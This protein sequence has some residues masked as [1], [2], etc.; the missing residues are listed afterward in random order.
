MD[1]NPGFGPRYSSRTTASVG[2][3]GSGTMASQHKR[4]GYCEHGIGIYFND[5]KPRNTFIATPGPSRLMLHVGSQGCTSREDYDWDT[6]QEET[7]DRIP[8]ADVS[9]RVRE[10]LENLVDMEPSNDPSL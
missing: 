8:T 4:H 3:T 2:K 7:R 5:S 10:F 9:L 6:E 1:H